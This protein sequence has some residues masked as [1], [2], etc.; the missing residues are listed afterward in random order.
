MGDVLADDNIIGL[1]NLIANEEKRGV[2]VAICKHFLGLWESKEMKACLQ[3]LQLYGEGPST[4]L[5][6]LSTLQKFCSAVATILQLRGVTPDPD[7]ISFFTGYKGPGMF[8]KAVQAILTR[9]VDPSQKKIEGVA[10]SREQIHMMVRDAMRTAASSKI[11]QP[12]F[13][14]LM[15]KLEVEDPEFSDL[16]DAWEQ[17]ESFR[18]GLREG[19]VK[20]ME[21]LMIKVAKA[22]GDMLLAAP[23]GELPFSSRNLSLL[24]AVLKEFPKEAGIIDLQTQVMKWARGH[25][26]ALAASEVKSLLVDF[27]DAN[28]QQAGKRGTFHP[29]DASR[30][31]DAMSKCHK[32]LPDGLDA[33]VHACL[34]LYL[35]SALDHVPWRSG[36]A[37]GALY[38]TIYILEF[39]FGR[40]LIRPGFKI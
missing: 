17:F 2:L 3:R 6:H 12:K 9:D 1:L 30:L 27:I 38:T 13:D 32:K 37:H 20:P 10:Q 39:S 16:Q 34:F 33:T 5:S 31:R 4:L 24:L 25:D 22:K 18:T 40:W 11:Q 15:T 8:E 23:E 14:A 35:Q 36:S 26:E 19:A 28:K 29:M 21:E 7:S